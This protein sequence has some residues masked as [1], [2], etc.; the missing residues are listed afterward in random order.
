M[1]WAIS[2]KLHFRMLQSVFKEYVNEEYGIIISNVV[3]SAVKAKYGFFYN[4]S[5][6]SDQE[7]KK[8][9]CSFKKE[10]ACLKAFVHF[11]MMTEEE[12][13]KHILELTK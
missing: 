9:K 5:S 2:S 8:L 1:N 3:Y 10:A 7:Q 12:A 6:K 4:R 13:N 11:G